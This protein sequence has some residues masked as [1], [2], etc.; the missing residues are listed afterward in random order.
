MCEAT[1]THPLLLPPRNLTNQ[2]CHSQVGPV[3]GNSVKD[4]SVALVRGKVREE[5]EQV[6]LV[7]IVAVYKDTVRYFPKNSE[8]RETSHHHLSVKY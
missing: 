3:L 5:N 1:E 8:T 4:I 7:Y 6:F 2:G